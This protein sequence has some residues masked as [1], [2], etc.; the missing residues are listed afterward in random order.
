MVRTARPR[1]AGGASS[2]SHGEDR[3]WSTV[4]DRPDRACVRR[5]L[6]VDR[7]PV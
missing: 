7:P 3:G 4:Q 2:P 6:P 5:R 1:Y